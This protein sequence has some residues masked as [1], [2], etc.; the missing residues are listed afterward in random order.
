VAHAVNSLPFG[1]VHVVEDVPRA[2]VNTFTEAFAKHPG[3][4]FRF[5]A[6]GGPTA[7]RCYAL[8]ADAPVDWNLVDVYLGDERCV[9]PEDPDANQRMVTETLIEPT[10]N[11][12]RFFPPDVAHPDL[13]D[14]LLAT[15]GPADLLHLG[16]GP[17]GHTASLFSQSAALDVTDHLFVENIDPSGRNPHRRLTVTFPAISQAHLVVFTVSGAEKRQAFAAVQSGEDLPATRVR[18]AEVRWLV[19]HDAAGDHQERALRA[20]R[21]DRYG[22]LHAGHD[23]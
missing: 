5:L 6:S 22:D 20:T 19:D 15:A 17:D 12:A 14:Q 10:G 18:A 13:Y 2:F 8:L 1:Q 4:R 7:K 11:R 16:L 3:P 21:P 9:S 23:H